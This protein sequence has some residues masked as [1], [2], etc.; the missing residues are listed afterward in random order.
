ME[1]IK[2]SDGLPETDN[3]NLSKVVL[4]ANDNGT[5]KTTRLDT[6]YSKKGHWIGF[7]FSDSNV[8]HWMPLPELPKE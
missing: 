4:A 3:N 7:D 1:W 2:V 8:T 5:I 6:E